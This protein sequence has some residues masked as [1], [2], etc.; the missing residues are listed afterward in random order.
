MTGDIAW[1]VSR[2]LPG[3]RV[4]CSMMGSPC[5]CF[6]ARRHSAKSCCRFERMPS[7]PRSRIKERSAC[8]LR[9][10]FTQLCLRNSSKY[11]ADERLITA[12]F[13]FGDVSSCNHLATLRRGNLVRRPISLQVSPW[14]RSAQ[15]VL[16][17]S[18]LDLRWARRDFRRFLAV[19]MMSASESKALKVGRPFNFICFSIAM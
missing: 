8:P 18:S 2:S 13:R 6:L 9:M 5:S 14:C 15:M 3:S 16:Q 10:P 17:I 7:Y 1:P 4:W 12:R 19:L 11:Y